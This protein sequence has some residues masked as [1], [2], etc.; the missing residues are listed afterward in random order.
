MH[1]RNY[2]VCRIGDLCQ[3]S[4]AQEQATFYNIVKGHSLKLLV[5]LPCSANEPIL[6]KVLINTFNRSISHHFACY[7]CSWITYA[8]HYDDIHENIS[9]TQVYYR[10]CS[11]YSDE[12]ASRLPFLEYFELLPVL[13]VSLLPL[14]IPTFSLWCYCNRNVGLI[15]RA[16]FVLLFTDT[17]I[18]WAVHHV[19]PRQFLD[20]HN[21]AIYRN[22]KYH[23]HYDNYTIH[24]HCDWSNNTEYDYHYYCVIYSFYYSVNCSECTYKQRKTRQ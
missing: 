23:H 17:V 7:S 9:R 1:N 10:R 18:L 15:F 2:G 11:A 21:D 20:V 8:D 22:Y 3:D 16:R 24:Q 19:R 14:L 4:N 12:H 6:W 5:E 13:L